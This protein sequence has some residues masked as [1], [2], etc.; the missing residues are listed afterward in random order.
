MERNR[1][2]EIGNFEIIRGPYC[3]VSV[4]EKTVWVESMKGNGWLQGK[5]CV[6]LVDY[7]HAFQDF[8]TSKFGNFE[9]SNL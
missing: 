6:G 7:R 9:T 2:I 8:E 3:C 5:K 4:Y 1:W